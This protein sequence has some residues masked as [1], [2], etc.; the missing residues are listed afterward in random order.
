MWL[1]PYDRLCSQPRRQGS[2]V[3]Q[4]VLV[5][6]LTSVSR[7]TLPFIQINQR[8]LACVSNRSIWVRGVS[9]Q[10]VPVVTRPRMPASMYTQCYCVLTVCMADCGCRWTLEE[11]W[12]LMQGTPEDAAMYPNRYFAVP[13]ARTSVTATASAMV[14]TGQPFPDAATPGGSAGPASVDGSAM[15]TTSVLSTSGTDTP[16]SGSSGAGASGVTYFAY[17]RDIK[18]GEGW[19]DTVQ[20]NYWNSDL[21]RKMKQLLVW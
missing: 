16:A 4:V 15:T 11:P 19:K 6:V 18:S 8:A 20:L 2:P 7:V 13:K 3:S 17:G 5:R 14:V 9:V 10:L 1:A 12:L 21:R